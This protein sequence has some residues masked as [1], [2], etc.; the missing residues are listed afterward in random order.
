MTRLDAPAVDPSMLWPL[1]TMAVGYKVFFV[2]LLL[3]RMKSEL[4]TAR[5]RALSLQGAAAG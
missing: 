1:L 4:L 2:T 3:L 5:V